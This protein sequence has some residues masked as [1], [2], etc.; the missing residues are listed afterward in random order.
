MR[1]VL[2]IGSAQFGN[3]ERTQ[4]GGWQSSR[5]QK[6]EAVDGEQGLA[7]NAEHDTRRVLRARTCGFS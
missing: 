2:E 3:L 4:A 6:P 5:A 7:A 1:S